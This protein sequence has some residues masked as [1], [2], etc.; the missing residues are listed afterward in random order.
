[1]QVSNDAAVL[2]LALLVGIVAALA[3][4]VGMLVQIA[5]ESR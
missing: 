5:I 2:L 1:V 3:C 4:D